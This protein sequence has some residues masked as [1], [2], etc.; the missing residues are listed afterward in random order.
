MERGRLKIFVGVLIILII[1]S[2]IFGLFFLTQDKEDK[3][4]KLS[5]KEIKLS[6]E[7]IKK[8]VEDVTGDEIISVNYYSECKM[9]NEEYEKIYIVVTKLKETFKSGIMGDFDY[10]YYFLDEAGEIF[11]ENYNSDDKIGLCED[12]K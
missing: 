7:E 1:I 5:E 4:V 12:V 3:E 8:I 6:N 11:K 10:K 9:Y 2:V